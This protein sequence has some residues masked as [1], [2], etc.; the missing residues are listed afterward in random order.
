MWNIYEYSHLNT[1]REIFPESS[2]KKPKSDCT[3]HF[4]IDLEPNG[5]PF[6]SKS[7]NQTDLFGSESIR[8]Q[9]CLIRQEW[10]KFVCV[11]NRPLKHTNRPYTGKTSIPFPF[12]LNGIW[13]WGEISFRFW[14]NCSS[15]WFK[16]KGKLSTRSYPINWKEM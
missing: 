7:I 15:I 14:T 10:R 12:T 9:F 6:H 1:R 2:W 13:S 8:K 5:I 11:M 16:T 3:Y 4:T